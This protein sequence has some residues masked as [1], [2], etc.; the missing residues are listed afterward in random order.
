MKSN[1]EI[2]RQLWQ[3][4]SDADVDALL[5]FLSPDIVWESFGSGPLSGTYRGPEA[6][7]DLFARTGE[8]VDTLTVS[9]L[10]VYGSPGGAVIHYEVN[11]SEGAKAL[12]N[13]VVLILRIV[14]GKVAAAR[15]IPTHE[16][17]AAA[18]WTAAKRAATSRPVAEA[19]HG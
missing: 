14:E 4:T 3:A 15:S 12:E 19:L 13:E 5:S 2:A 11:A 10:D 1:I 16:A 8:L 7:I 18:F 9:V 17:A 6:V